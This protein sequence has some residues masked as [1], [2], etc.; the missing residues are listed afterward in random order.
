[1]SVATASISLVSSPRRRAMT[2]RAMSMPAETPEE[3]TYLPSSTQ[4][5]SLIHSTFGPY[6]TSELN[7][8]LFVVARLPSSTPARANIAEPLHTL[9]TNS[10]AAARL[11]SQSSIAR[12]STSASVPLPPGTSSRSSCGQLLNPKLAT[13][14]GPCALTTGPGSCATMVTSTVPVRLPNISA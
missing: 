5:A 12:F 14:D 11:V 3:V 13:T 7:H 9:I 4:R 2:A 6:C 1:Y 10:A 8:I